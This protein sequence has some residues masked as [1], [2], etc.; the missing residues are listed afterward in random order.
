[1]YSGQMAGENE[2]TLSGESQ[3]AGRLDGG[4]RHYGE[5]KVGENNSEYLPG[6]GS[7]AKLVF[8]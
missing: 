8:V 5:Q 4:S 1:M 7:N 2:K 6:L 3:K